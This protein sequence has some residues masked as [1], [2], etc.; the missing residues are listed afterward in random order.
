LIIGRYPIKPAP[1]LG[2]DTAVL[3]AGRGPV[4][5]LPV[6]DP[7]LGTLPHATAM[8]RSTGHW[9]PLLNGYSSYYP[10]GFQELMERARQLPDPAILA[11]LQR[12][13]G[14][15]SVVVHSSGYRL[16]TIGRWQQ[17]IGSGRLPGVRLVYVDPDVLVL[18]LSPADQPER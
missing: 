3:R 17:L 15:A 10:R 7:R 9:R 6:G 14:L 11:D 1:A 18:D 16:L 4:L 12:Q 5:E 8:Y 2:P 13:T